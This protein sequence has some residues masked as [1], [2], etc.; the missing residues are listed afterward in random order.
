VG[1]FVSV[2]NLLA[3]MHERASVIGAEIKIASKANEET[4]IH[5]TWK[6]KETGEYDHLGSAPAV[7]H[8]EST[9]IQKDGCKTR[10][11]LNKRSVSNILSQAP[12]L[13]RNG[14]AIIT[15]GL[16]VISF[17]RCIIQ[18]PN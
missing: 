8:G 7:Y 18:L 17:G 11:T 3:E 16:I 6:P 10:T 13:R 2:P 4:Q 9:T 1:V 15:V 5:V 12:A 14:R